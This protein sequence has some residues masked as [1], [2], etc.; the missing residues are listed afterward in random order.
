MNKK[1]LMIGVVLLA[2]CLSVSAVSAWEW[3]FSSSDSSNTDGGQISVDNGKL[4]IQDVELTLPSGF[5]ENKTA[6]KLAQD[7]PD[8]EDAKVSVAEFVKDGKSI[9]TRVIFYTNGD[10]FTSYT[11]NN[12]DA[13]NAT[14]GGIEGTYIPD[15]W[16]DGTPT[17]CFIKD[18][19]IVQVNAPDNATIESVLKA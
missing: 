17:F 5:E 15:E 2:I 16:G 7:S 9:V 12:P 1:I 3:S 18:G 14:M 11:P 19:K 6:E 13:V 4:K 10:A 8:F